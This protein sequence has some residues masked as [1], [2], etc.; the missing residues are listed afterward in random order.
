MQILLVIIA[1]AATVAAPYALIMTMPRT[2]H[3]V[4]AALA[5]AM[6]TALALR[7]TH[8]PRLD[9][10]KLV[11]E[12]DA[13]LLVAAL[14][15]IGLAV[16]V[17]LTVAAIGERAKRPGAIIT[18]HILGIALALSAMPWIGQVLEKFP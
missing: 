2:S 10:P 11:W 16:F 18:L 13:I 4:V 5:L 12:F 17:R 7:N 9:I 3:A 6:P 14:A 15:A 1:V 8:L